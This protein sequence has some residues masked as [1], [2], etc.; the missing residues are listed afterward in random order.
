M[1]D[2]GP[3]GG[4]CPPV[5]PCRGF[6]GNC[7]QVAQQFATV[8]VLPDYPAGLADWVC[9]EFPNEDAPVDSFIVGLISIAI[10]IPVTVFI[11]SCFAIAN[12]SEAPESWL[13]WTSGWRKLVFGFNAHRRWH[14][15]RDKPP[16]R[17]VRWYCRSIGAPPPETVANLFHSLWA[18]LTRTD[19]PWVVEA[20]EAEEEAAFDDEQAAA[21]ETPGDK[22][23]ESGATTSSGGGEAQIDGDE[24][25]PGGGSDTHSVTSSVRSAQELA[26]HKRRLMVYGLIGTAISWT[27]FVW[28]RDQI[29]RPACAHYLARHADACSVL[30]ITSSSSPVRLGLRLP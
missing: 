24:A 11:T 22:P 13:E 5:G 3:D 14:W 19:P 30:P 27:L 17:H 18:W 23:A 16:V 10:C 2:S 21:K 20:R 12:D 15:T 28:V 8:P 9:T 29:L 4:N 7:G 25:P 1:L 26:A 6:E